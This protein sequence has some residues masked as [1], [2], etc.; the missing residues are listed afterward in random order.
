LEDSSRLGEQE[1]KRYKL[2]VICS[3]VYCSKENKEIPTL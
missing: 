2:W 1:S 3:K